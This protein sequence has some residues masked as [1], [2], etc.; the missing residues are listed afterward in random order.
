MPLGGDYESSTR[1]G[2]RYTAEEW[3]FIRALD[4]YRRRT[5][6]RYP[7]AS[8]VLAVLKALGYRKGA[9][10]TTRGE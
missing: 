4:A 6:R 1:D 8:E 5:G 10:R 3:E 7:A 9:R 2:V